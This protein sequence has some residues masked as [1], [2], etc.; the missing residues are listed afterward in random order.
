M[1]MAEAD[2]PPEEGANQDAL[3]EP[4]LDEDTGEYALNPTGNDED[5]WDYGDASPDD[6]LNNA[7]WPKR[8]PDTMAAIEAQLAVAPR[9]L[10]FLRGPHWYVWL[11]YHTLK[12]TTDNSDASTVA[13]VL[14]NEH[15]MSPTLTHSQ[16][17]DAMLQAYENASR[18]L[19]TRGIK[20]TIV[21]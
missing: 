12:W 4:L 20:V 13:Q 3:R 21:P 11:D 8:T 7:D 2:E 6:D 15:P 10:F 16:S 18:L 17:E 9:R 1:K 19:G 14:N 5:G